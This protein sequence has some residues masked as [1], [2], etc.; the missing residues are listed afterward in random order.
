MNIKKSERVFTLIYIKYSDND[1]P[2]LSKMSSFQVGSG[3]LALLFKKV[4]L[5]PT[6]A[7]FM[8]I[9]SLTQDKTFVGHKS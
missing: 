1:G 2:A 4:E 6:F 9:G 7:C 3:T 5:D 8:F